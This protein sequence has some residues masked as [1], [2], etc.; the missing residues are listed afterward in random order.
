MYQAKP[1]LHNKKPEHVRGLRASVRGIGRVGRGGVKIGR[2]STATTTQ[3]EACASKGLLVEDAVE[4]A[5]P[6]MND[7]LV[8]DLSE[9]EA[10]Q[11]LDRALV[12]SNIN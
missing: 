2:S 1:Q 6:E 8:F 11:A 12:H 3:Q 7:V 9:E 5:F 10:Q 4:I